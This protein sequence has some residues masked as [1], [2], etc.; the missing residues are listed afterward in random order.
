[1]LRR[2][3]RSSCTTERIGNLLVALLPL[4]KVGTVVRKATPDRQELYSSGASRPCRIPRTFRSLTREP[5]PSAQRISLSSYT[6]CWIVPKRVNVL[7]FFPTGRLAPTIPRY[8]AVPPC[9]ERDTR[10]LS[11]LAQF[12]GGSAAFA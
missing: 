1:M 8:S 4:R 6:G 5:K 10:D 7:P 9:V 12:I 2:L 3:P 11:I